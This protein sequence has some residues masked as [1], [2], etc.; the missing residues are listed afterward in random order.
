PVLAVQLRLSNA[1]FVGSAA[2]VTVYVPECT[3]VQSS[4]FA[5][6]SEVELPVSFSE[7]PAGVESPTQVSSLPAVAVLMVEV[8]SNDWFDPRGSVRLMITISPQLLIVLFSIE[9][10][11]VVETKLL[12]D[13]RD[14]QIVCGND[15]HVP[16]GR[17]PDCARF[18]PN[19]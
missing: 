13:E 15:L 2:S 18:T 3:F 1:Q 10:S 11:L 5:A 12:P 9:T 17:I 14:S 16:A 19:S 6:L 8:K 4:V 7:K